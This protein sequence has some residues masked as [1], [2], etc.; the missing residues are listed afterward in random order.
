MGLFDISIIVHPWFLRLQ[1]TIDPEGEL[2][3]QQTDVG[4]DG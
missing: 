2:N 4:I 3:L 1:M